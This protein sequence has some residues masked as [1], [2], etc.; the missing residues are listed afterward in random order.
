MDSTSRTIETEKATNI[1]NVERR[2][3][4]ISMRRTNL[5]SAWREKVIRGL[6]QGCTQ[7]DTDE[8]L[9]TLN[10]MTQMAAVGTLAKEFGHA[11]GELV[12]KELT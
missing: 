8:A 7:E 2:A 10:L 11:V 4:R 12:P 6:R 3:E 5:V 9:D 1:D